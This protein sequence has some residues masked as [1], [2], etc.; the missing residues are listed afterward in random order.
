MIEA[1]GLREVRG[2]RVLLDDAS[3]TLRPGE[4]VALIG[5]NGAG[6]ST[7]IT[8]LA[9]THRPKHGSVR[10]NGRPLHGYSAAER[11]RC[12]AYLAQHQ[13]LAWDLEVA[14]IVALGAGSSRAALK[15]A[16]R[17]GLE[18]FW[19]RRIKSLSGGE[20]ARVLLARALAGEPSVLLAD[21]PAA[22]LDVAR[23]RLLMFALC[24]DVRA[25]GMAG[26]VVM[27]DLNLALRFA[28]RV[29]LLGDGRLLLDAAPA[30]AAASPEIDR[31]FGQRFARVAV[32]GQP[33]LIP[34]DGDIP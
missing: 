10:L 23:E 1:S 15:A 20:R 19:R 24:E 30:V 27:H 17:F 29:L 12:L 11:A 25:R 7:L 32:E 9:G 2:G 26:L 33:A 21:E 16:E 28:D 5:P 34:V 31:T 22:H 14:E 3:L 13:D 18:R 6:K 4:L 8:L